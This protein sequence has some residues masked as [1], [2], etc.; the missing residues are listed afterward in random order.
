MKIISIDDDIN[1]RKTKIFEKNTRI[2]LN[3]F[4]SNIRINISKYLKIILIIIIND[5]VLIKIFKNLIKQQTDLII[6][7][8]IYK[9]QINSIKNNNNINFNYEFFYIP[10]VQKQIINN[11]LTNIETISGGSGNIGNALIMV[12]HLIN[13]CEKIKC[14][15]I[16]CPIGL[17]S[18]IKK[19]IVNKDINIT[20]FPDFYRDKIKIDLKLSIQTLYYNKYVRKNNDMRL[21]I[22]KD[23][24]ISNIP[25]YIAYPND[26]YINIRSGDIFTKYA[27]PSYSQPPLCFYQKIIKENKY[28][29]IFLLSNGHENPCV[30]ALLKLYPK[31]KYIHGSPSYDLSVIINSYNLVLPISTFTLTLI[32]LNN[33]LNN[34]Y[35]YKIIDYNITNTNLTMHIMNP[36]S[37]YEKLMKSKWRNTTKQLK[38]MLNE[39]C[40]NS[41]MTS[42]YITHNN[43]K[44][45]LIF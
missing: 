27:H 15:N 33:N 9:E 28:N 44:S 16:I 43:Y 6:N 34:L 22:L 1:K 11:N 40:I 10:E 18:I 4:Q 45:N 29:N 12:N 26:L 30:E 31:I 41:N 8:F 37:K 5:F 7:D 14:K 24:I 2:C 42:S 36:S 38:L 17:D 13:I 23:E 20:I 35:F 39:D 32:N 3:D 21:G 25:K 19:P